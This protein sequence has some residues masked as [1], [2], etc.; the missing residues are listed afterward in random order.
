MSN[1]PKSKRKTVY[2]GYS[3]IVDDANKGGRLAH[4][5]AQGW[6]WGCWWG[7]FKRNSSILYFPYIGK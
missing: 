2:K 6:C 4:Y 5:Q 3:D 1:V 7:D